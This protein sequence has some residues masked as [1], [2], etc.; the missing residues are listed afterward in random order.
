MKYIFTLSTNYLLLVRL[1]QYSNR[2]S[3]FEHVSFVNMRK[4][5]HICHIALSATQYLV[6]NQTHSVI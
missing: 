5:E 4:L 2:F 1:V 3:P 6:L